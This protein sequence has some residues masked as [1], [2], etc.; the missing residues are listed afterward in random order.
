ME[1]FLVKKLESIGFTQS[2]IDECVFYRDD[3]IFIVYV[4]DG[5]ENSDD[6]ISYVIKELSDIGLQIEDQGHPAN[7]VGVNNKKLLDGSYKFSQQTLIDSII[8][9]VGVT[10]QD[11]NKPVSAKCTASFSRGLVL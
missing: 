11:F 4:D 1:P 3:I 10:P 2:Q 6:Q 7:Y 5:L 8:A 9:D